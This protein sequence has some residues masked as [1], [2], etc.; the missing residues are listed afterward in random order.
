MK[1]QDNKDDDVEILSSITPFTPE[2]LC[3]KAKFKSGGMF[4][5]AHPIPSASPIVLK[6]GEK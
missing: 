3:D 6:T 4:V 1:S 5:E 2:E